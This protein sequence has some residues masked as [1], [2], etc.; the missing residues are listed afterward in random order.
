MNNNKKKILEF[1]LGA[2]V[3]LSLGILLSFTLIGAVLE[4]DGEGTIKYDKVI[5]GSGI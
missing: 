2:I 1:V 4:G 3:S 5:A